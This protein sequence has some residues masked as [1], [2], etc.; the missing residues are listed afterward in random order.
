MSSH[1]D[2]FLKIEGSRQ[3][4][5]KGESKATGKTG[6]I[7]IGSWSWGMDSSDVSSA[8]AKSKA[9][10]KNIVVSKLFNASSTAIMSA[11]RSGEM[12]K[13]V[14]ISVRDSYDSTPTDTLSVTLKK[15]FV[16]SYDLVSTSGESGRPM[17]NIS[18]SFKEIEVVYVSKSDKM[19][20]NVTHTFTD[21]YD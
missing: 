8:Q 15:A 12:L 14:V 6:V 18:F 17:E 16:V 7:E 4:A 11:L 1:S 3:G 5:I 9:N 10:S 2:L 13:S 21:Q 20:K 19:T